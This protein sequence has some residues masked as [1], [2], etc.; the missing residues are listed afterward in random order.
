MSEGFRRWTAWGLLALSVA[1]LAAAGAIAVVTHTGDSVGLVMFLWAL[2]LVLGVVGAVIAS[3]HSTNPIGWIFLGASLAASS[4]VFAEAYASY[5][6]ERGSGVRFLAASLANYDQVSWVPFVV[7]PTT[8]LLLLVPGGRLLSRRWRWIGWFA[9]IGMIGT[10]ITQGLVRGPVPA[11]PALDNPYGVADSS[12][13]LP[14]QVVAGVLVAIGIVGSA[15]SLVVRFRR[16][17]G[18][19]R[20]Q[21]KWLA[22]AG[23]VAG[24][25]ILAGTTAGYAVLGADASNGVIMLGVMGL[26]IATGIAITRYRLYDIDVVINR[27]LVYGTLTAS[28]GAFYL[29]SVLLLQLAL[30]RFISGSSLAVAA[31]TLAVA[32]LFGPARARTQEL[33]DRQ[34]FRNRYDANRALQGFGIHLRDQVD[35]ADIGT[36]LLAVVRTTVQPAHSSL[37]LRTQDGARP[38]N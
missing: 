21:L 24:L 33:V 22:L 13:M 29:T 3:R 34:F 37:W 30:N 35:L 9:A 18:V 26:P 5:Y 20:V 8:F 25:T 27:A 36:E 10:F 7:A 12:T 38:T 19:E 14:L 4:T 2:T 31:S 6:V 32:A 23:V 16:A 1:F 11:Y 15:A 17:R 28:L